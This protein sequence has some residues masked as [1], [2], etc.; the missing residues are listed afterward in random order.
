MESEA[1]YPSP[2]EPRSCPAEE[3]RVEEEQ[4]EEEQEAADE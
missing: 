2:W 4:E 3:N 1:E